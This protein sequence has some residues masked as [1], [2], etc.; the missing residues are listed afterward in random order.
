MPLYNYKV[1]NKFGVIVRG[2]VESESEEGAKELL[3]ER[4]FSVLSLKERVRQSFWQESIDLF[5][6]VPSKDL[7]IFARQFSVMID[8]GV[9]EVQALRILLDQTEHEKLKSI[10]SDMAD[11]VEGGAKISEAMGKYPGVFSDFFI[12]I[13]R[14]GETTGRLAEVVS[15]LA[16]QEEKDYD[17]RQ[18]IRG[19]LIYPAFIVGGLIVVSFIMMIYV[20]PNLTDVLKETGAVLPWST[21]ALI[22]VSDFI[23]NFWWVML[24]VAIAAFIAFRFYKRTE[25]GEQ[26][27][28]RFKLHVPILGSVL[29]KLYLVRF[30]RSLH[31][32]FKGDVDIVDSLKIAST[33]VGNIVYKDLILKTAKQVEDGESI[34]KEFSKSEIMPPMLGQ[35]LA[36]GEQSGK[37]EEVLDKLT[38]FYA[39]EVDNSVQSLVTLIEPIVMILIGVAVGVMV[40][41][42]IMPMYNLAGQL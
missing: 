22:A 17:L 9:R 37:L 23:V 27:W 26:N 13:I 36:V 29:Q 12:G 11:E 33:V 38:G 10:I 14:S 16:D 32:L 4:E 25:D 7:V 1:K 24:I 6:R 3:L 34:S 42:V 20:V 41:A 15:Y 19:A 31:T 39:R 28:D 5:S 21:R 2:V 40:A 8:S 18:R 30:T 35:M